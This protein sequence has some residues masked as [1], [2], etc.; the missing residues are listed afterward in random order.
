MF[1]NCKSKHICVI[2]LLVY[3]IYILYMLTI[4]YSYTS[5]GL[6]ETDSHVSSATTIPAK[7]ADASHATEEGETIQLHIIFIN[8]SEINYKYDTCDP[9]TLLGQAFIKFGY[10]FDLDIV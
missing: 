3:I 5:R 2:K 6:Q 8:D 10:F 1:I 9:P 7:R 4:C